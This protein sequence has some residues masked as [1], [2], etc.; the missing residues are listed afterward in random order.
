M[1]ILEQ[2]YQEAFDKFTVNALNIIHEGKISKSIVDRLKNSD[3]TVEAIGDVA[4]DITKRIEGG[5]EGKGMNISANTIVNGLNVVVGELANLAESA[6]ANPLDPEQKY[7]AYSWALSRYMEDAVSSGKIT[8][9]ELQQ[10]KASLE[11]D[12]VNEMRSK[13][14][15][16]EETPEPPQQEQPGGI[17]SRGM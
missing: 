4:L 2:D 14:Q 1:A 10:M 15:M 16:P 8:P 12:E 5:A 3:D 7:Q 9:Q 17:L 6:G 13:G 11:Q